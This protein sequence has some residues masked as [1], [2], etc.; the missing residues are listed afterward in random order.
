MKKLD[1][2]SWLQALIALAVVLGGATMAYGDLLGDLRVE[3]TTREQV[4]IRIERSVDEI[5]S[6]LKDE[7][8]RHHPRELMPSRDPNWDWDRVPGGNKKD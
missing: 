6:M 8:E 1:I 5:K 2:P 3:A 4:D 7:I